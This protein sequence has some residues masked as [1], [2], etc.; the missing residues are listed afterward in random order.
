MPNLGDVIGAM[1]ADVAR[2][3]VRA[4]QEAIR[5]AEIYSRDP[6]LKHFSVP[7]FRLPD[8]V[9]DLPVL[10][11]DGGLPAAGGE[12]WSIDEPTGAEL[13]Q[14]VSE[15]LAASEVKLTRAEIAKVTSAVVGRSAQLFA[16]GDRSV[17]TPAK[18]ASELAATLA[19]TLR[20]VG[21]DIQ[22][23]QLRAVEAATTDAVAKLMTTKVKPTPA[24]DVIVT[25]EA[26]KA[27]ADSDSIVRLRMTVAEDG[28]ELIL[29]DDGT[30][31]S[32]APE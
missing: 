29:R 28:Y 31:F 21:G 8:L 9:I 18:V 5:I 22:D 27:H 11:A 30:G 12:G 2:A 3:R 16:E 4:D 20:E 25:A 10:V 15:A 17:L 13:R 7:R 1:L 6:L 19:G 14:A 24:L 23:E 32:L 26:L